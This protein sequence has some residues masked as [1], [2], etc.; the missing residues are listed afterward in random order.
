MVVF[1]VGLSS[2]TLFG[3]L[4]PT[5]LFHQ[6]PAPPPPLGRWGLEIVARWGGRELLEEVA[7]NSFVLL[8]SHVVLFFALVSVFGFGFGFWWFFFGG[9]GLFVVFLY[10]SFEPLVA[11]TQLFWVAGL[12]LNL[13]GSFWGWK[14][15][16]YACVYF[17]GVFRCSL[18]FSIGGYDP[19]QN[20]WFWPSKV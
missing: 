12:I 3:W 19:S 4:N 11:G 18:G 14:Q 10:I 1:L 20:G 5:E 15:P 8:S 16:L 7:T 13:T 17:R 6:I 9:G 2:V